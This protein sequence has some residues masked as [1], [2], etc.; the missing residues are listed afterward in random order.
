MRYT[1]KN[2]GLVMSGQAS[3][4]PI[5]AILT[6]LLHPI[7]GW[8]GMFQIIAGLCIPTYYSGRRLQ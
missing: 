3:A 8:K 7:L 2:Y 1:S 4:A 5:T 6:Q